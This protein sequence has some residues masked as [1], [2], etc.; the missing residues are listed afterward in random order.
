MPPLNPL[1]RC[2]PLLLST[3]LLSGGLMTSAQA[4]EA[5]GAV[6]FPGVMGGYAQTVNEHLV[7]RADYATL[8]RHNKDG[9]REGINYRG[10]LKLARVGLFADYFPA[11]G[12]G[13]RLTGG[14][15]VND[16]SLKLRS[17]M[18]AG[19]TINVGGVNYIATGNEYLNADVKIPKVTPYIGIGWG[20]HRRE[21]GWGLIADLGV[22]IGKAKLDVDTNLASYGV[23][24]ADIDREV[25]DL[26]DDVGKVRVVPQLSLGASYR[27]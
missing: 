19:S 7:L 15:T 24:Q 22:S 23:Q 4:G 16:M 18:P 21:P 8:G 20:H 26:R 17:N 9:E 1:L 25:R 10:K 11:R 13:F 6:G 12:S 27:F 2:A 3:A 14:L 5:Y